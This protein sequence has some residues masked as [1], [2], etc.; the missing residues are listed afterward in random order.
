MN[1]PAP[2]FELSKDK[3]LQ[4]LK[5]IYGLAGPGDQRSEALDENLRDELAMIPI[6]IDPSLFAKLEHN[7]LVTFN[8]S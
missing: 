2:E 7:L 4:I 5:P 1:S 6:I 3:F 8:G